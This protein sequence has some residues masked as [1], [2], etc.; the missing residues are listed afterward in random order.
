MEDAFATPFIDV[1]TIGKETSPIHGLRR[2]EGR[3]IEVGGDIF[4]AELT[5]LDDEAKIVLRAEFRVGQFDE[6][7]RNVQEGDLF[8]VTAKTIRSRGRLRTSYSLHLRH[9][10]RWT[11]TEVDEINERTQQR[12]NMLREN[13][14]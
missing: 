14:E 8:Y 12:L 6:E 5:P 11:Q 9:L 10:G 2:W 13:V 7:D 1:H 4:T 3:V